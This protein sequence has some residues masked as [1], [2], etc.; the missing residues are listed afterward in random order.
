MSRGCGSRQCRESVLPEETRGRVEVAD[1]ERAR[2]RDHALGKGARAGNDYV[3]SGEVEVLDRHG[4]EGER[5]FLATL[6][7]WP[8]GD[9]ARTDVFVSKARMGTFGIVKKGKSRRIREDLLKRLKHA[10]TAPVLDEVVMRQGNAEAGWSRHG[11]ILAEGVG[12]GKVRRNPKYHPRKS[13]RDPNSVWYLSFV[14]VL[15]L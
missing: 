14:T 7:K 13:S 15:G 3:V 5:P 11:L 9:D 10:L 4:H 1:V 2:L 6:G 12:R 8:S